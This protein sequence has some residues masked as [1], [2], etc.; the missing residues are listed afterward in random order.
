MQEN[1]FSMIK[2]N[3]K[4]ITVYEFDSSSSRLERCFKSI[5][6]Q[7]LFEINALIK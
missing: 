2:K 6:S 3:L 1:I 5:F 7:R 4:I